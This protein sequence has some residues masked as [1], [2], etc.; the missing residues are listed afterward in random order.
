MGKEKSLHFLWKL[1]LH[2]LHDPAIADPS[3]NL[4]EMRSHA[5]EEAGKEGSSAQVSTSRAMKKQTVGH[6]ET[7]LDI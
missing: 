5:H 4:G 2:L 3:M 7:L 1:S 6:V